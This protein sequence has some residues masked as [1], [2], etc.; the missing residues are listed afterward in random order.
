[1]IK[2]V[3]LDYGGVVADGGRGIEISR[4]L[5]AEFDLPDTTVND[6]FQPLFHEF[7]RGRIDAET[8]WQQAAI[9]T[10]RSFTEADRQ[11]WDDWWGVQPYPEMLELIKSLKAAGYPVGLLS[12]IIPPPKRQIEAAH[13]YSPF[14]FTVLSCEVGY[15]KPDPEMYEMAL[16]KF[17][18][19]KSE[20]IVFVDD[21]Q[22]CLP[23]AEALG[24]KTILATSS[25]QIIAELKALGL[26]V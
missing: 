2:G 17:N 6:V 13:G 12:N 4:R 24:M 26:P 20:E 25:E 1:M 8:F 18:G 7:T 23:P 10:G 15:A 22:K 21:Q 3:L 9:R 5:C 11:I 14:D 19:L 16:S